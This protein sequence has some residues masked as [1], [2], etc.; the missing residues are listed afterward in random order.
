MWTTAKKLWKILLNTVLMTKSLMGQNKEEGKL[1]VWTGNP[2]YFLS[3]SDVCTQVSC[4]QASYSC[5]GGMESQWSKE[6]LEASSQG[7]LFL[8]KRG[9]FNRGHRSQ[10]EVTKKAMWICVC[11]YFSTS[12]SLGNL[13]FSLIVFSVFISLL[14]HI[15]S[16]PTGF[17]LNTAFSKTQNFIW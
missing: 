11:F 10:V 7:C 3:L 12:R 2:G 13:S 5:A 6:A 4:L 16:V 9:V 8:S 17:S 14:S 15:F 1:S